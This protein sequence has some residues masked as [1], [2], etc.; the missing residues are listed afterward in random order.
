MGYQCGHCGKEHGDLPRFFEWKLP[1]D[2]FDLDEKGKSTFVQVNDHMCHIADEKHFIKCELA[3]PIIGEPEYMLGFI[4]WAGVS[5][6]NFY[7]YKQFRENEDAEPDPP[8]LLPGFL[9]GL[10]PGYDDALWDPIWFAVLR[11]DPI[12]YIKITD[13]ES[14]LFKLA[15]EG[16]TRDYW[17]EVVQKLMPQAL[18]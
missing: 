13:P 3:V 15:N 2:Y 14:M 4:T 16:G 1:A 12:P 7:M 8:E 11:G 9:C 10:I 6:D 5:P 17:H 18:E